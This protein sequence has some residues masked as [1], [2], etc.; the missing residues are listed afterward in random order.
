VVF[1]DDGG[2]MN[3]NRLRG[4]A[5]QRLVGEYFIPRLGGAPDAW[6]A[7][8][9]AAVERMFDDY[10]RACYGRTDLD[11]VAVWRDLDLRW[12]RDMCAIVGV[13][14]PADD[15]KCIALAEAAAAHITPRVGSA[16]PGAAEA[17]RALHARGFPLNTASGERSSELHGYLT[18]M[19]VRD[20]FGR[21]Y[22][23]D[24][25]RT[26]K[27]GPA[28]YARIFADAGVDPARALVVDDTP[29][30]LRWAAEAG[31]RTLLVGA[32]T[33]EFRTIAALADL[34]ALIDAL[35][36]S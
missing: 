1:L 33:P 22:G 7:A 29:Q 2:V 32:A 17:I 34:P 24:L 11:A 31:A 15:D 18:G 36:D 12:L 13:A 3:D 8:N 35:A 4:P 19:G 9:V 28:Y 14:A 25:V 27:E 23:P 5:W 21:L 26:L 10:R 30:P 20:C 6:A 16:F